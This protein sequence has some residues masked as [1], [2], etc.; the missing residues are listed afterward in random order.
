MTARALFET[1]C[2][3]TLVRVAI[4]VSL[5]WS[6]APAHADITYIYDELGRLRAVI[7]PSQTDGTAICTYDAAGNILS[8]TRQP[9]DQVSPIEF[10]PKSGPVGTTVTIKGTGFSTTPSQNAVTFNGVAATVTSATA[11]E[12]VTAVPAGA[13]TGL[14]G[15]TVS[16]VGSASSSESFTVTAGTPAPTITSI[17]PTLGA[18]GTAVQVSGT[19]FEAMPAL[20]N[21]RFEGSR[22]L[23]TV[24]S[25]TTTTLATTAPA[26]LTASGPISVQTPFG[27][28]VSSQDFFVPV[29]PYMAAQVVTTV[30]MAIGQTQAISIPTA[31]KIALV[32][33]DGTAGQRVFFRFTGM[34]VTTSTVSIYTPEGTVLVSLGM[35]TTNGFIDTQVL[36]MTGVYT[37]VLDPDGA[38]TGSIT[39]ALIDAADVTGTI[40][41]GGAAVPV[42]IATSGQ[43]ARLSFS[44]TTGQRV[45]LR[46]TDVTGLSTTWISVLIW[47]DRPSSGFMAS[48]PLR[49]HWANGNS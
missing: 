7:D 37:L 24:G 8:I 2:I 16:G 23:A 15:L 45:S 49:P 34:Q 22:L 18:P 12:L 48:G 17:S 43:N 31:T 14:I 46:A 28:A 42:T 1:A 4:V 10:N 3:L 47:K 38:L 20:N 32:I 9:S 40:T 21:L 25:A 44:G 33:F 29:G 5:F 30:R 26:G 19:S 36:P 41:P 11:T 13:S 27:K 35:S 39:V 6:A